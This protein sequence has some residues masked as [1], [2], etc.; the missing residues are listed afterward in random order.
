MAM[1]NPL[2]SLRNDK[3]VWHTVWR[4]ILVC[5]V[6]TLVAKFSQGQFDCQRQAS[7]HNTYSLQTERRHLIVPEP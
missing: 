5:N 6:W 7:V 3:H 1:E 4:S 2:F